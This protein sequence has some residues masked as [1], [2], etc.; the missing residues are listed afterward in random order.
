M[1]TRLSKNPSLMEA[2]GYFCSVAKK[3]S[4]G[5]QI[6]NSPAPVTTVYFEYD[7]ND[8]ENRKRYRT[9]SDDPPNNEGKT[10]VAAAGDSQ[11]ADQQVEPSSSSSENSDS[12]TGQEV[13]II[14]YRFIKNVENK[15]MNSKSFLAE[16]KGEQIII[17]AVN[18]SDVDL[19]KEIENEIRVYKVLTKLQGKIIPEL[20]MYGHLANGQYAIGL[21]YCGEPPVWTEESKK[22][23]YDTLVAFHQQAQYV[24]GDI[25]PDQFVLWPDGQMFLLDF[26]RSY[27]ARSYEDCDRMYAEDDILELMLS[28]L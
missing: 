21:S 22:Q 10:R 25:R 24:H 8:A 6:P 17:K 13:P 11:S 20:K 19:V 2:L 23:A 28:K 18:P 5:L 1:F 26:G 9:R 12:P 16:Y 7:D 14:E 15:N 27:P 3:E 4:L